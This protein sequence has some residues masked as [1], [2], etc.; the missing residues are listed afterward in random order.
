[1]TRKPNGEADRL[2]Q[3]QKELER[4]RRQFHNIIDRSADATL[5][6]DLQGCVRFANAAAG[7]LFNQEVEQLVGEQFG[8]PVS[9][10]ATTEIE[11][12]EKGQT[13]RVVEMRVVETRWEGAPALVATLRD[14]SELKRTEN[15]LRQQAEIL[16]QIHDAVVTTDIQGFVT[17]WNRGAERMLGYTATEAAGRHVA[18]IYRPED[19]SFRQRQILQPLMAEGRREVETR[20]V[21]KAGKDIWVYL[22]LAVQKDL[23]GRP[24]GVVGYALDITDRKRTEAA[25]QQS[26]ARLRAIHENVAAGLALLDPHYR[27][28]A[29]NDR[30]AEM[31]GYPAPELIGK[32]SIDFIWPADLEASNMARQR[33]LSHEISSYRMEKRY[34]RRDGSTFW[35]DLSVTPIMDAE[36][37]IISLV[38]VII[39]I[40]K[41][42]E[43]EQKLRAANREME[44]FVRTISHDL[45]SPLSAIIGIADLLQTL[46]AD[47]LDDDSQDLLK[48]ISDSGR[49]MES[50]L[51][52]LLALARIGHLP[53]PKEPVAV[54]E[55]VEKVQLELTGRLVDAGLSLHLEELPEVKVPASLLKLVFQN[56]IENAIQYG[57]SKAGT[58]HV[59]GERE[60]D[61]ARFRVRDHGPGVA[62]DEQ[63]RIFDLFYRGRPSAYSEGTGIG[64]ATVKKIVR[65]YGGGAWVEETPGG[66]ATFVVEFR[67]T[68]AEE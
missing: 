18:F 34:L 6:I 52:D 57:R 12:L 54:G 63:E 53:Q 48:S 62:E 13:A 67:D 50:L 29:V 65:L 27:F 33:L 22:S 37:D 64:L 59:S 3:L 15:L 5:I 24:K 39:N 9:T 19:L 2:Q 20:L 11:I 23:A 1:M 56:L 10:T 66:G 43:N 28:I 55:V 8:Y 49:Q 61:I 21:T 35:A 42:K 36:G 51:T 41:A 7:Q 45:R 68:T 60:G 30:Y 17:S 26:E 4:C 58:I 46:K 47:D 40:S 14:I 38:C 31:L 25:L 16:D 44:E 32:P